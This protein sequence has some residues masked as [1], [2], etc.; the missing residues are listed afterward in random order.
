MHPLANIGVHLHTGLKTDYYI[1]TTT[2]H[3]QSEQGCSFLV[4]AEHF[5]ES[6]RHLRVEGRSVR[7]SASDFPSSWLLSWPVG[8]LI[9]A[10]N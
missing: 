1:Q 7:F 10:Q 6:W 5:G 9:L 2:Y 3:R 4:A 8:T